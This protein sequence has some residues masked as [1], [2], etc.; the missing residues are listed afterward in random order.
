MEPELIK[1]QEEDKKYNIIDSVW[2]EDINGT[3]N[4]DNITGTINKDLIKGLDGN[5]TLA[6]KEAGD[7][8][9]GGNGDDMIYGNDGRDV[10]WGK[11]GNDHVEG[12]EGNDRIYGDRGND[13]LIGG[14]SNDT[15]TGG[16]DRDIFICGTATDT[17]TDFNVTQKDT[18]P[19]NDCENI[20]NSGNGNAKDNK[21]LSIQQND[22]SSLGNT[23]IKEETTV[24][25]TTPTIDEPKPDSGLFFGLF[26]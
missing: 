19:E 20:E 2:A 21:N 17:I 15:L 9:S 16:P 26:K 24:A 23:D 22:D 6:G 13:T 3:E 14:P 7:D 5:D 18:N 11:A 25:N 8:I 4:G 10:L 1:Q 12:G